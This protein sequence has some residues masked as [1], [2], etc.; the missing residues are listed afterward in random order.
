MQVAAARFV[1]LG[2]A[3]VATACGGS[4]AGGEFH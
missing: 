2:D 3:A 1:P 4:D